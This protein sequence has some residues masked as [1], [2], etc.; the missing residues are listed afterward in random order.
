MN[1]LEFSTP[2]LCKLRLPWSGRRVDICILTYPQQ[3]APP[4]YRG[5]FCELLEEGEL[6]IHAFR[7]VPLQVLLEQ[8]GILVATASA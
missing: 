5:G 7:L 2:Q 1:G 3:K 6:E 8:S 4:C